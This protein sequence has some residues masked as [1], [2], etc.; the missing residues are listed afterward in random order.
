MNLTA[1]KNDFC[2]L[3]KPALA[4]LASNR[5]FCAGGGNVGPCHGDSGNIVAGFNLITIIY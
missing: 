3:S 2:F 5:T 1:V 4:E